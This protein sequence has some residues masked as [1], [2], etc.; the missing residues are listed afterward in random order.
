MTRSAVMC[1]PDLIFALPT[2]EFP[3]DT[4][5]KLIPTRSMI[6]GNPQPMWVILTSEELSTDSSDYNAIKSH[7]SFSTTTNENGGLVNN[8]QYM[9]RL[10]SV[11]TA[12]LANIAIDPKF[13]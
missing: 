7:I 4:G 12:A 8:D 13:Q 10:Q 2:I 6:K 5:M 3:D 11:I 9:A 1:L